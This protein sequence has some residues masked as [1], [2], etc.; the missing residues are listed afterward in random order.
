MRLGLAVTNDGTHILW[1]DQADS[2][3]AWTIAGPSD[4]A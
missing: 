3:H 1:V 2:G 4:N